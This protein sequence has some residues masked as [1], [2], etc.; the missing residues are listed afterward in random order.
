[1]L[2]AKG[3]QYGMFGFMLDAGVLHVRPALDMLSPEQER[4]MREISDEVAA[5]VA[6]YVV[7]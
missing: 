1:M 5:L 3:L 2:D 7:V 6:K 4:L